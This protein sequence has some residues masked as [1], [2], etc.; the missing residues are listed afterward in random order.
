[1]TRR[2][3]LFGWISAGAATAVIL[4]LAGV[5]WAAQHEPAF[6]CEAMNIE[7]A[8]L[9]KGS[10]QMLQQAAAVQGST[11]REGRWQVRVTATEINGWFAVDLVKNH[12]K[13]LPPTLKN[14]RVAIDPNGITV[15]CQFQQGSIASVLSLTVQPSMPKSNVLALRIAKAR[16]GLLPAPLDQVIERITKSA[17]DLQFHVQWERVGGDP[18]ALLTLPD[19][20][21]NA[22]RTTLQAVELGDGEIRIA[23]K[24]ER[25]KK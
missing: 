3:R 24:T 4:G 7:P 18:V 11:T 19:D 23:G 17:R 14:P 1:M 20:P 15:A 9:E 6:Y 10:D 12:P 22:Y 2:K 13:L 8:A 21:D 5:Y 25:R 16:A